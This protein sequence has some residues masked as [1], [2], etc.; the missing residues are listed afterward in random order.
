MSD[1]V[2]IVA[3]YAQQAKTIYASS[4]QREAAQTAANSLI[5]TFD[6]EDTAEGSDFWSSVYE[7]LEQIAET[8]QLK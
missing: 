4:T 2:K 6:W 8:G 1:I 3:P 5:T 7:R